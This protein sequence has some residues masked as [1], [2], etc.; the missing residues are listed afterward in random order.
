MEAYLARWPGGDPEE[1][2]AVRRMVT[3]LTAAQMELCY[4]ND[5]EF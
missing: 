1:Q 4:S 2:E 5:E 3:T